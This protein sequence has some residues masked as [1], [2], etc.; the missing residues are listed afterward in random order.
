MLSPSPQ[1]TD[2]LM[3]LHSTLYILQLEYSNSEPAPA[4]DR[5]LADISAPSRDKLHDL[6]S[7]IKY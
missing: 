1:F 5:G 7:L 2:L 6:L 3:H 4:T